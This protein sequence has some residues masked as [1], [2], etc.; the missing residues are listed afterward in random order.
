MASFP[1]YSLVIM[2]SLYSGL[3]YGPPGSFA[4]TPITSSGLNTQVSGPSVVGGQTQF[5]IT[6]GT[7]PGNGTNLFHSFGTFNV[8]DANTANFLNETGL[9][10][11][12]ILGRVNGGNVSNIFGTI[13]TTGF[14]NANLFLMNPAGF[15]FGPN[16]AVN[17][18]GMVSFTS[19]DY[20]RLADGVRFNA[21]PNATADALLSIAPVAAFGFLGKNPGA[22]AVQGSQLTVVG[23]IAELPESGDGSGLTYANGAIRNPANLS[24]IGGDITVQG[25]TLSA[26]GAD[27]T[28]VSV[29]KPSNANV[30]GEVSLTGTA[31]GFGT[32]GTVTLSQ[33]SVIDAS[34]GLFAPNVPIGS[35]VIRGGQVVLDTATIRSGAARTLTEMPTITVESLGSID[36]RNSS[37]STSAE[38]GQ[39]GTV[40]LTAGNGIRLTD[41][42]VST[43]TMLGPS[44][45]SITL[46][47]PTIS[48]GGS[49]LVTRRDFSGGTIRLNSTKAITLTNTDLSAFSDLG[50]GGTILING[51]GLFT[52]QQTTMEAWGAQTGGTIQISANKIALTGSQLQAW[53][54][55]HGGLITLDAK[56][57]TLTNSRLVSAQLSSFN[58]GDATGGTIRITSPA[59][60]QTGSVLD[61][62]SRSDAPGGTVTING[63]TQ[64]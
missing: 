45:G 5:N 42:S 57:T 32:M 35:V 24:F 15:L 16:A 63:V 59:F 51:G 50:Q 25:G 64:P 46:I 62:A 60:K 38:F 8:P 37:V 12:N 7:R 9:P 30:G 56:T 33:G 40:D 1:P 10:T 29:G 11:S 31:T 2:A 58:L 13:H 48:L 43:F 28:L 20:L 34:N 39:A 47:A 52:A 36:M 4:Q 3:L 55:Q 23:T 14:G 27:V 61:A 6:G 53:G 54:L 41:S 18:G 21:M 17:V 44:G 26:P 22:I 49:A 19:A